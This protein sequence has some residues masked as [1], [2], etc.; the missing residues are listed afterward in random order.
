VKGTTPPPTLGL[1]VPRDVMAALDDLGIESEERGNEAVAV[2]PNPDQPDRK[3]SWSCNLDTGQHHC[4]ACGFGGSFQFLVSKILGLSQGDSTSWVMKRKLRDIA[5][6]NIGPR[7]VTERVSP[8]VSE[9]DTWRHTAPPAEALAS[10]SLT[11]EACRA[12]DV[13]WEAQ[14]GLWITYVRDRN[15]RLLGWQEKNDRRFKNHP[16]HLVK[17]ASLFGWSLVGEGDCVLLVESPLDAPYALPGCPDHVVPASSY[18]A[19][20]S[21]D[22]V[23]LLSG[24]PGRIILAMDDDAAGWKSVAALAYAFGSVPAFVFNY[25]SVTKAP[26]KYNVG[27]PSGRDPGNLSMDEIRW[28]IEHAVPARR[29][30]IPWLS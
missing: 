14:H 3:P 1:I 9:A 18:G 17:S 12:Y 21:A 15:G 4:F 19:H 6:G 26:G 7:E 30:S 11:A 28:G 29:I 25:G 24:R 20:V 8:Y 5:A 22:Q 16:K 23:G 2:C 27:E 13:G 10:R